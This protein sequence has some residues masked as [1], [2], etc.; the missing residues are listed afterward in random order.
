MIFVL[1]EELKIKN[2]EKSKKIEIVINVGVK[3]NYNLLR[4]KIM[5]NR[6]QHL[7]EKAEINKVKK[8]LDDGDEKSEIVFYDGNV[9]CQINYLQIIAFILQQKINILEPLAKIIK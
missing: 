8:I 3:N 9:E 5:I 6:Q 2:W 1:N 7:H 4:L